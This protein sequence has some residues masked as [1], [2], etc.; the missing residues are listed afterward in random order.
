MPSEKPQEGKCGALITK[1]EKKYGKKMYCTRPA[2]MG[3]THKGTGKC[4]FHGGSSTGPHGLKRAQKTILQLYK[5]EIEEADFIRENGDDILSLKAEL[6]YL[7]QLTGLIIDDGLDAIVDS[8]A[9][10][11]VFLQAVKTTADLVD[12]QYKLEYGDI[13]KFQRNVMYVLVKIIADEYIRLKDATS[14]DRDR[15][16]RKILTLAPE[17]ALIAVSSGADGEYTAEPVSREPGRS[18]SFL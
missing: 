18:K 13:G 6:Y 15:E 10:A 4:K 7:R 1:W 14:E 8:E 17:Q 3:T 9:R 2:G 12:K 16:F 5:K 11:R